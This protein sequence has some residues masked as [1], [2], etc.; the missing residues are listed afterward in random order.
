MAIETLTRSIDGKDFIIIQWSATKAIKM[1]VRL[2]S[3]LGINLQEGNFTID[4]CKLDPEV[5]MP[6]FLDM[7]SGVQADGKLLNRSEFDTLFVGKGMRTLYKLIL[8]ILEINFGEL[9]GEKVL[10]NL[11]KQLP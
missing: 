5:I 1:K 3:S 10:G 9:L 8:A 6:L 7:V 2:I 4:P 11:T